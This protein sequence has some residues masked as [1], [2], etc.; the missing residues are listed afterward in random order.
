MAGATGPIRTGVALA[1]G[2]YRIE[3]QVGQGGMAA[4]YKAHDTARTPPDVLITNQKMLDLLLQRAEDRPLWE[5]A[6]L[7]YVVL[8]E[9]HTYDGAQGTDVAM[10]L[11]RLVR[12][13]RLPPRTFRGC[14]LCGTRNG[15]RGSS[16][17]VRRVAKVCSGSGRYGD[18]VA[19]TSAAEAGRSSDAW[20]AEPTPGPG[21]AGPRPHRH[22]RSAAAPD[23]S[24]RP[25]TARA[26]GHASRP[27]ASRHP[28]ITLRSY[29]AIGDGPVG[30]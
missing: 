11:R 22:P 14:G 1:G 17:G 29:V 8:D 5:G 21:A 15:R 18:R 12:R 2:R 25:A 26:V 27:A 4:V 30:S 10:L 6:D 16:G 13:D 24:L 28:T 19:Y 20:P 9:F 7:T 3:E 23:R